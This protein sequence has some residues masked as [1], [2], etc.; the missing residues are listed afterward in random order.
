MNSIWL[1]GIY[2]AGSGDVEVAQR[3]PLTC[4]CGSEAE[5]RAESFSVCA[6]GVN[7]ESTCEGSMRSSMR[8]ARSRVPC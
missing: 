1:R 7:P 4:V 6:A 3:Q 5:R 2:G 8:S